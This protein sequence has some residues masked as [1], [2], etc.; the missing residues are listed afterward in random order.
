MDVRENCPFECI[1]C[2]VHF[3]QFEYPKP[4]CI[5][6]KKK[7]FNK[8]FSRHYALKCHSKCR[9]EIKGEGGEGRGWREGGVNNFFK[10][11]KYSQKLKFAI[12]WRFSVNTWSF[13]TWLKYYS[14]LRWTFTLLLNVWRLYTVGK[15]VSR[16][17]FHTDVARGKK[18]L[19]SEVVRQNVLCR[20]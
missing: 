6:N 19:S 14:T 15:H 20:V 17:E 7:K 1:M 3:Y 2:P 4:T 18:L 5:F 8:T 13:P 12:T 11:N 9:L 16:R 10:K